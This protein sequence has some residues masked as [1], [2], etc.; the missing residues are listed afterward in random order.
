MTSQVLTDKQMT[1]QKKIILSTAYKKISRNAGKYLGYA[2][3]NLGVVTGHNV[4]LPYKRV[5]VPPGSIEE[6]IRAGA[7]KRYRY[8]LKHFRK[9]GHISAGDWDKK[10]ELLEEN[11]VALGFRE[12][13]QQGREWP[14]TTYYKHLK[15]AF[16]SSGVIRG[17]TNWDDFAQKFHQ[18]DDLFFDIKRKNYMPARQV[19]DEVEVAVGRNGQIIM[20]DGR[21]RVMIAKILNLETIPVVVNI[22]HALFIAMVCNKKRTP[23]ATPESAIMHARW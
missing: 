8:T 21:H 20:V 10:T 22:W 18:W 6:A 9:V 7:A 14:E 1:K 16:A 4:L 19:E 15:N 5:W 13:Y 2:L 17:K 23:F 12:R 3:N 11:P